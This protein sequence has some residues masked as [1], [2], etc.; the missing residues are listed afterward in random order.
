MYIHAYYIYMCVCYI[1]I[2]ILWSV[3]FFPALSLSISRSFFC[4][5]RTLRPSASAFCGSTGIRRRT[6]AW[7]HTTL[8]RSTAFWPIKS[9]SCWGLMGKFGTSGFVNKDLFDLCGIGTLEWRNNLTIYKYKQW[10]FRRATEYTC[11]IVRNT[12]SLTQFGCALVEPQS[13][14]TSHS[15]MPQI[16]SP[17]QWQWAGLP[18]YLP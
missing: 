1:L 10:R 3:D 16:A 7:S 5:A 15:I 2:S 6:V 11:R 17:T 14:L 13:G 8:G 18:L 12:I 9:S 4:K